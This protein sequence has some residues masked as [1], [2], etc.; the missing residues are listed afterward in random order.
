MVSSVF[1]GPPISTARAFCPGHITGFLGKV[2]KVDN[3]VSNYLF[4]GSLGAG[5]TIDHGIVTSVKVFKNSDNNSNQPSRDYQISI[6]GLIY[7]TGEEK[8]NNNVDVSKSVV[9]E[10]IRLMQGHTYYIEIEHKTNIPIGY[11]LASS[12]AAA[13]S[14]SY[15]LN[16]ALTVGLDREQAAQIAHFSEIKCRTGLGSVIAQ[17]VGGFELRSAIGA[18]GIG[19]VD[20]IAATIGNYKVVI[21]CLSP[22]FTKSYLTEYIDLINGTGEKM[23]QSLKLSKDISDFL[24]M[25]YDFSSSLGLIQGKTEAPILKLKSLGFSCSVALFGE[26]VFTIV[27][28]YKVNEVVNGLRRFD[29]ILLVCDIDNEGARII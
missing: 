9:Q 16:N 12:G 21:L 3:I 28:S 5:V 22:I 6:N 10:Y 7:D 1:R 18:P 29:G 11:G 2:S 4:A 14:L 24:N 19:I 23:L 25:S 17:Y 20:K 27:P 15:A 8:D 13:L 26:T